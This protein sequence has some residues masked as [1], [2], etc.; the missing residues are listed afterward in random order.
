MPFKLELMRLLQIAKE[1]VQQCTTKDDQQC[2]QELF[3]L[4]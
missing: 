1:K 3:N 2:N 4:L